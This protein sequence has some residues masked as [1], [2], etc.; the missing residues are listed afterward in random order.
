[1]RGP[2]RTC[3]PLLLGG[4][5]LYGVV[6]AVRAG[7]LVEAWQAAERSDV[8]YAVAR[9][10]HE[11]AQPRRDQA[12]ALWRPNVSASASAGIATHETRTRGAR[13]SAP[14]SASSSGVNFDTSITDGSARRWSISAN[15]PLYAPERRAR[16][17]LLELSADLSELEWQAARQNLMLRTAQRYFDLA[18]AMESL[19]VTRLQFEAVRLASTEAQDRFQLGSIPVTDTY[20]AGARLA[21]IRARILAAENEIVL[22]RNELADSTGLP[23]ATLQARLPAGRDISRPRPLDAWQADARAGNPEI[24]MRDLAAVIAKREASKFDLQSSIS[25][26][27]VAQA[28]Q[29]RLS[30]S[31]DFGWALNRGTDRMIGVQVSVPLY[32]GGLRSARQEEA[33]HLAAK[34]VAEAER[35]RQQTAQQVHSAWLGLS[36]GA[37]RVLSLAQSL[38][39]SEARRDATHLGHETGQRTTLDVLNAEND[40]AAARLALVQARAE[41]SMERLRLAAL[42]GRLDDAVLRSVDE[43]LAPP[44]RD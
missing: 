22:R 4:L 14:G 36:V 28:S 27:L 32:T 12:T 29:D 3:V 8:D 31:G 37:E 40:A 1:M 24:R 17:Q 6:S 39:A 16:Q 21:A 30:G 2:A 13:F 5:V 44:S 19:R 43:D 20:E 33:L 35:S 42:A 38:Q 9:A 25:V 41:L 10:A 26:D 23:A 15:Q 7:D 18:L 34:A 11:A